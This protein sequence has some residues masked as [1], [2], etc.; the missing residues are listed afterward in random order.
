MMGDFV[1]RIKTGILLL[2]LCGLIILILGIFGNLFPW[3]LALP[4]F[5]LSFLFAWTHEKYQ[6]KFWKKAASSLVQ[7]K[8]QQQNRMNSLTRELDELKQRIGYQD[9]SIITLYSQLRKMDRRDFSQALDTL[10]ETVELFTFCTKAS[11][12]KFDQEEHRLQLV[13]F[14]GYEQTERPFPYKPVDT[15]IQGWAFRNNRTFTLRMLVDNPHLYDLEDGTTIMAL[16]FVLQ[17]KPWGIISLE[18]MP[19]ERYTAYTETLLE[20]LL[21]VAEPVLDRLYEFELTVSASEWDTLT[22]LPQYG[23]LI[24]S[25]TSLL[26]ESL[27]MGSR[28]SLVVLEMSGTDPR[29]PPQ[30]STKESMLDLV[31][32]LDQCFPDQA[33]V[34]HFKQDNQ[35]AF[36][37]PNIDEDGTAMICMNIL[38][39]AT[40]NYRETEFFIGYSNS[41]GN[42]SLNA[43]DMIKE[44]EHILEIQKI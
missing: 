13:N 17:N 19:F 34:Y 43:Q 32:A 8:Y 9:E 33:R 20:I 39:E 11:L 40:R 4:I 3:Q 24:R 35:L 18:E 25:V 42:H 36:I 7:E 1:G 5:G 15:T 14:L 6:K 27:R 2:L 21:R 38:S 22:G 23:M 30:Q 26:T 12:W 29:K 44:V 37:L 31:D 16:P 41:R 28:F 10:L